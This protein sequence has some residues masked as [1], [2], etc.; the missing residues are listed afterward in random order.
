MSLRS[1][2]L[3]IGFAALLLGL[4][5][6]FPARVAYHWIS[7]PGVAIAGIEGSIWR[8]QARDA[9]VAGLR[10]VAL[11]WTMR[12]LALL[13]GRVAYRFS[14]DAP[15]GFVSGEVA[16]GVGNA[17]SLTDLE[18]SLALA[19]L[20]NLLGMP[21]LEGA[22]S[23]R[24][25]R[26]EFADGL[27]VSAKGTA[28]IAN[29]RAPIVHRAPVG[30]FRAEFFTQESGIMGS[31]EDTEAVVELA[32]SLSLGRDGTYQFLGKVAPNTRTPAD[33]RRQMTTFLGSPDAR[34]QYDLR[35]EGRL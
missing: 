7:P 3:I 4:L 30:G 29:L 6:L 17:A 14:A 10:F 13:T 24:F 32:G 34:G 5:A 28:E 22:A 21:G 25:E 8:G 35:L 2:Y 12:P 19:S 27:P 11:E 15:P 33:L 26:L 9:E 18:A 23:L 16:L 1:R 31:I 20:Q